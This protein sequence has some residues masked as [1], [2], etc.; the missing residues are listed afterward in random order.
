MVPDTCLRLRTCLKALDDI[1]TPA[2]A[3]DAGFAHEQLA[4]IKKSL[5]LAIDQIPYEYVFM[6]RDA[7]DHLVL[8]RDLAPYVESGGALE[9]RL[10]GSAGVIAALLPAALPDLPELKQRLRTLKQDVEDT[11][12][13]LCT[14]RTGTELNAIER[15]VL[16]HSARRIEM[17]RA[18]TIATGFEIDPSAIP[19]VVELIYRTADTPAENA[20]PQTR[21]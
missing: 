7:Q 21:P 2:L 5:Q 20:T 18:W 1:V 13:G 11:V 16:D 3:P 15:L 17:E 6:V 19:P 10:A 9:A 8:A 14:D 12:D 4:L